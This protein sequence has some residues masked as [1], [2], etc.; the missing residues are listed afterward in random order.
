M[1]QIIRLLT[2]QGLN[3]LKLH[4]VYVVTQ[5]AKLSAEDCQALNSEVT[6]SR[7]LSFRCISTNANFH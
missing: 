4:S 1:H 6:V 5:P 2:H 3:K 7:P